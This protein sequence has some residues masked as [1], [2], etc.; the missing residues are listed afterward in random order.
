MTTTIYA[1]TV[2]NVQ[3]APILS[4]VMFG[5]VQA[6]PDGSS[7]PTVDAVIVIPTDSLITAV[8]QINQLFLANLDGI[9]RDL[10]TQLTGKIKFIT[11]IRASTAVKDQSSSDLSNTNVENHVNTNNTGSGPTTQPTDATLSALKA[12]GGI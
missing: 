9:E 12:L 10:K 8:N 2:V 6:S 5:T 7:T 11:D 4:K 3:I 1:D